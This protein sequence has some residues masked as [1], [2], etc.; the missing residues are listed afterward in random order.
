MRSIGIGRTLFRYVV[1][2]VAIPA[3][4][5]LL[6]FGVVVLLGDLYGYASLVLE[7][8]LG[9]APVLDLAALELVPSLARTIPLATVVGVLVGLGT[10]SAGGERVALEAC[11]RSPRQIA[12]PCLAFSALAAVAACSATLVFAPRAETRVAR[13]LV[14]LA[15]VRPGS[16][17]RPGIAT[18]MGTWRIRA[19][20]VEAGGARLSGV[21]V[22]APDLPDT[23][24]ASRGSLT[25]DDRG[26]PTLRLE[27]GVVLGNGR[28]R[29]S[30]FRFDALETRVP[31]VELTRA[32]DAKGVETHSLGTLLD[33]LAPDRPAA[34][35]RVARIELHRR[36]AAGLSPLPL[37]LLATAI[38]AGRRLASRAG[39]LA[40]GVIGVV[41]YSILGQVSEGLLRDPERS[42]EFA[43]W[44]PDLVFAVVAS[45]LFL[46]PRDGLRSRFAGL[47][48]DGRALP[49]RTDVRV[50]MRSAAL[51]RYVAGRFLGLTALCLVGITIAYAIVD[52]SDNLKW[53]NKYDATAAE[54]TRFFAARLPVL[55]SRGV[56]MALILAAA[57]TTSLLATSGELL[58]ARSCGLSG[59]RM[60]APVWILC[61]LAVPVDA[62]LVNQIVPQ[63]NARASYLN[64]TEI[65]TGSG[66]S[67]EGVET[68]WHR[69]GNRIYELPRTD[70]LSGSAGPKTVYELGPDGR[71]LRRM[72]AS[73]G[74]PVGGSQ[75][76]LGDVRTAHLEADRLRRTSRATWLVDVGGTREGEGDASEL[77]LY[78]LRAAIRELDRNGES[79]IAQRVHLARRLAAPFACLVL[80]LIFLLVGAD[81]AGFTRPAPALLVSL[82]I[83]GGYTLVSSVAD[84]L[85]R[86][87][88]F[89]PGLAGWL[90][91]GL[92]LGFLAARLVW[93]RRIG[94]R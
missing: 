81:G 4:A 21:L 63:A 35:R 31:V 42:V 2:E 85:G 62:L 39:A 8:G 55:A 87:G 80:P 11:G 19:S 72:D 25:T 76:L 84:S 43:V 49:R 83:A 65:K 59:R 60:L 79:S 48:L 94:G 90:P 53:F 74:R 75:W 92:A 33:G 7:H 5:A 40:W 14:E 17:L 52:L 32:A 44:L 54:I 71:P 58:G 51:P 86:Q 46:V 3:L 34:D 89:A 61:A 50:V 29:A 23:M 24:F 45:S 1:R 27:E 56:P 77:T 12:I 47:R 37:G 68:V 28:S 73:R 67:S 26:T 82:A 10:L 36:L 64:R 70:L 22:A 38:G 20:R 66:A 88:A 16:L 15:R 6:V 91:L 9:L 13:S 78:A 41:A 18:R 69:V 57:L 93:L 30:A